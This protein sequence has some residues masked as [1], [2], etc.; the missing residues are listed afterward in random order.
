MLSVCDIWCVLLLRRNVGHE[1]YSEL[2]LLNHL[3]ASYSMKFHCEE[4]TLMRLN[5]ILLEAA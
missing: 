2:I 5:S 1:E 3:I 4:G